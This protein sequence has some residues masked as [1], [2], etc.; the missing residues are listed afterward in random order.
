VHN[1]LFTPSV[2]GG[3]ARPYHV[4]IGRV[5]LI[6]GVLGFTFGAYLAWCPVEDYSFSIP[7]TIGGILQVN[8]QRIGYAAIQE[9]KALAK[10]LAD[11]PDK[12]GPE[13]AELNA[14]KQKA[15]TTHIR[16]GTPCPSS[17]S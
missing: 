14:G 15:L 16:G 1:T 3:A 9:Y 6:L 10:R 17:S 11:L 13:A 7:I 12:A 4:F 2:F 5:G 8:A